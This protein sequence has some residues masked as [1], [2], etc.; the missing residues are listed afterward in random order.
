LA[1]FSGD[2]KRHHIRQSERSLACDG[3]TL[4]GKTLNVNARIAGRPFK[5][6]VSP[7]SFARYEKPAA[8]AAV[9]SE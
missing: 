6:T 3:K 4:V 7:E 1:V 5:G 9:V 8:S 2:R